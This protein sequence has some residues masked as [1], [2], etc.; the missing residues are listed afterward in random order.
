MSEFYIPGHVFVVRGNLRL[1]ACDAWLLPCSHRT[2]PGNE[3]FLK[4]APVPRR[5][6]PFVVGGPRVQPLLDAALGRPRPWL[7]FTGWWGKAIA[8]Y[9]DVAQEFLDTASSDIVSTGHPTLFG[10]AKPLLALSVVGTG[11]GGAAERAGE[12][13]QELLPRLWAFAN[14]RYPN[15]REFDVALVCRDAPIYAAAQA[16]RARQG[17]WPN[18][19]TPALRVEAERVAGLAQ[20]G[21]LALF[22]GAGVSMAAGYPSWGALLDVLAARAKMA[23]DERRGLSELKNVLDQAT[24]VE[25]RL[26]AH[27]ETLGHAVAAVME[28]R[29]HYALSHA[30]LASLPL[31]EAITTNYDQLFERAW[32]VSDRTGVSVIP[33]VIQPNARRWLLKMHGC[34]SD[35]DR[36][37]LSRSSYTRYDEQLPGLSGIVQSILVT[38]HV[39]FA[40]FSLNDDN[41]HRIVDAVRRLRDTD[42]PAERF[43]TVL[44]L[45]HAGL[46]E[47]LWEDDLHRVRM[48]DRREGGAFPFGEAARRLE[49]FLDYLVSRTRGSAHLLVGARFDPLLS[50]GEKLLRDSLSR[51]VADVTGPNTEDVRKTV[52]WPQIERL[53]QSL[54]FEEA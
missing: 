46:A 19:L 27:G 36:V 26:K 18:D 28:G 51:F 31:R 45:G 54:G 2:I 20:R 38:R 48:D 13:V 50:S 49:I 11:L 21:E 29:Q 10:R 9:V 22:L 14:R 8:W 5:G 40:G 3:W 24:I 7:G 39:L 41:F 52:A 47:V 23:D 12:V 25:R 17:N 32:E 34:L 43:G 6:T 35:P 4:D 33:G 1:F 44:S 37:V 42:R 16:E 30:L 15:G 53:L